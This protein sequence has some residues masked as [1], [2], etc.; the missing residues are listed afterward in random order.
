W[1][2]PDVPA[3]G[4]WHTIGVPAMARAGLR[5]SRW[6]MARASDGTWHMARGTCQRMAHGTWHVPVSGRPGGTWHAACAGGWHV[7]HERHVPDPDVPSVG[8]WHMAR[9]TCQRL[10]RGT[11]HVPG[12]PDPAAPVAR[13]TAGTGVW[14]EVAHGTA[15]SATS[16]VTTITTATVAIVK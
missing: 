12:V 6:H 5:P 15:H 4:T 7:A 16:M 2:V 11:W 10:S 3:V 8:T 13:G 14:H 9:G 1:H